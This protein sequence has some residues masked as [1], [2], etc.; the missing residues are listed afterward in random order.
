[1]VDLPPPPPP[2]NPFATGPDE[3]IGLGQSSAGLDAGRPAVASK[4][5]RALMV[6]AIV[7]SI[8]LMMLYFIFSG[9][10]KEAPKPQEEKP[11]EVPQEA[12]PESFDPPPLPEAPTMS[13]PPIG[14][15]PPSIPEPVVGNPGVINPEEDAATKQQAL[16]RIKSTMMVAGEGGGGMFGGGSEDD[17]KK[18]PSTATDRNSLFESSIN[19]SA[20]AERVE[21]TSIGDLNRTVAQGRLIHATLESSIN[22]DL[23]AP[24]RAIVSRDTF[25]E[26]GTVPLIPKGSRLIGNYNTDVSG[27]QSR[28]FIVWTRV[29]RPDGIDV[30]LNSPLVDQLGQAGMGGQVDTKFQQIFSRS[31]LSSVVSIAM[32]IGSDEIGGGSA[33][34]VNQGGLGGS[35]TTGD[36]GTLATVN[37]LNRLG[38]IS[39]NFIQRFID[40]RPTIIVDQGAVINVFVNRDLVFPGEASLSARIIN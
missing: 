28:V 26:A 10:E 19:T 3:M 7:G 9:D 13:A 22:T 14:I 16:A 8:V 11:R 29:I 31:I 34:Q 40:A 6:L 36:A 37:A 27:G 39:D 17:K 35:Q 23:P 2:E 18:R 21:A 20:G 15:A 1:M 25:G 32:A 5:G 30:Q 24:I 33:T 12:P 4:P 38:T